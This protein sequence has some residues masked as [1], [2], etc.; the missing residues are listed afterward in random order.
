MTTRVKVYKGYIVGYRKLYQSDVATDEI[1]ESIHIEEIARYTESFYQK[2]LNNIIKTT[3]TFIE[4]I[5]ENGSQKR[6]KKALTPGQGEEIVAVTHRRNVERTAFPRQE[7]ERAHTRGRK[8][9]R[10]VL[11]PGQDMERA[12]NRFGCLHARQRYT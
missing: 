11:T 1:N 9:E 4:D 6:L 2:S 12:L 8:I 10:I 5:G 7:G 3:P